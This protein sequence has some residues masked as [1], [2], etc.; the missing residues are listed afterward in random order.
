[1]KTWEDA[2]IQRMDTL[3]EEM[4]GRGEA[5]VSACS[6]AERTDAGLRLAYWG[7]GVQLAWPDLAAAWEDTGAALAT[8]DTAMLVYYLHTADGTPPAGKWVSFRELPAGM[9]YNQAFQG[10]SGNRLAAYFGSTPA[11]FEQAAERINGQR[12][13]DLG[14]LAFCFQPLPRVA[15]AAILWPGDEEFP[16]RAQILFDAGACHYLTIDGCAML[17]SGLVGRLVKA[18]R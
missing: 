11:D 8:Y 2:M 15:L 13:R 5:S 7:R 6:G 9:F 16:A 3:R 4:S 14:E 12:N 10:Y 18:A 1:M 17:G